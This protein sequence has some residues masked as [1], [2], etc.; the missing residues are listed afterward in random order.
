VFIG[1]DLWPSVRRHLFPPSPWVGAP[2]TTGRR[3]AFDPVPLAY[4]VTYRVDTGTP[5]GHVVR[6]EVLEVNR[7]WQTRLTTRVGAP[8]GGRVSDVRVGDFGKLDVRSP[9]QPDSV[10]VLP[11][12]LAPSD[13]RLDVDLAALERAG[14]IGQR[15]RRAVLARPCQVYRSTAPPQGQAIDRLRAESPDVVDSCVDRD[16]LVLEQV[17]LYKGKL[18]LRRRAVRVDTSPQFAPDT[19]S[20]TKDPTVPVGIGGGSVVRVDPA[21]AA[22]APGISFVL[23]TAPDGFTHEGRYA[24]VASTP[25]AGEGLPQGNRRAGFVDVWRNGAD[26]L[27]LDQTGM[28][29]GGDALGRLPL[30]RT[31]DAGPLGR[32]LA[33][34][35]ARMSQVAARL[36][37]GRYVR[38]AGT[39]PVARLVEI[40]RTLRR[41]EQP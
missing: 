6:T 32:A 31:V 17:Q 18:L 9:A 19:F 3:V 36:T 25:P 8:P 16:G 10:L 1:L 12:D 5:V 14:G 24:V 20:I 26:V 13:L 35:G 11:P 40:M 27:L 21:S 38:V 30:A 34:P 4:R 37:D 15:E 33:A 39:L 2:K 41:I 23:D 22:S 29:Y 28:T 7:P